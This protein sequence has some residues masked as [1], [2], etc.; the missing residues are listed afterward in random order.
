VPPRFGAGLPEMESEIELIMVG[1][2]IKN[3]NKIFYKISK[4]YVFYFFMNEFDKMPW[5][6][7]YENLLNGY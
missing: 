3:K 7:I 2:T 5:H 4:N 1:Y 6:R